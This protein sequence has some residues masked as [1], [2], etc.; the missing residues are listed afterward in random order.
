MPAPVYT[1]MFH[2]G[3][4][5]IG[6]LDLHIGEF[7]TAEAAAETALQIARSRINGN[8][9]QIFTDGEG[10]MTVREPE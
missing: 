9:V 6:Y 7:A 3:Y 10:R 4:W 5:R 1:I 2:D 8:G